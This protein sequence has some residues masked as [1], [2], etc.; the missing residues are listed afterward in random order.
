EIR[1]G[2]LA[3]RLGTR[4][5]GGGGLGTRLGLATRVGVGIPRLGLGGLPSVWLGMGGGPRLGVAVPGPVFTTL[6]F[7]GLGISRLRVCLQRLR[8]RRL[9]S[10]F[11]LRISDVR[12]LLVIE[13]PDPRLIARCSGISAQLPLLRESQ[14][15]GLP[16]C[17]QSESPLQNMY[18]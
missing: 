14:P 12:R 11:R 18:A 7:R 2:P 4:L 10:G 3:R 13:T 5:G 8:E 16:D 1:P 6:L 17:R 15:A 9:S